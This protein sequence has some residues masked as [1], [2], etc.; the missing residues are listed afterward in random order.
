MARIANPVIRR[1]E[2]DS[3]LQITRLHF[4]V[5]KVA[6]DKLADNLFS[7]LELDYTTSFWST[8]TI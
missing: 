3:V 2:S 8:E 4:F 5:N 6:N 7:T 1:S